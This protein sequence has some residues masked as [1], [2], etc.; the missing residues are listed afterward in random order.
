MDYNK[1]GRL[2]YDLRKEKGMTQKELAELLN[3]SD[4]TVSKWERGNGCPDV[5]L[6]GELS[7]VLGVPVDQL[8]T[9][10][11]EANTADGGNMKRTRF[12]V[13]PNCGN[14]L[15][16][17]GAAEISCCGRKLEALTTVP[18][19]AAHD[20]KIETIDD[21]LYLTLDH[22]MTKQHYIT[23]V[24]YV[25]YDRMI[26]VKLYPEQEAEVRFPRLRGGEFYVCCSEHGLYR[27]RYVPSGRRVVAAAPCADTNI[28][29]SIH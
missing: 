3:L 29:R 9:G 26:L 1:V 11:L 17:T 20:L 24:A 27:I 13:C 21:E 5:S 7:N 25:S 16:A 14:V 18:A 19:D 15:C 6:L 22:E 10:E 8:L 4:R 12:Y 28:R 2:I 23:F